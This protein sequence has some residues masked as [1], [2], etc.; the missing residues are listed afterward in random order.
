[1]ARVI[2]EKQAPARQQQ[3]PAAAQQQRAPAA[4]QHRAAPVDIADTSMGGGLVPDGMYIVAIDKAY[5]RTSKTTNKLYI[6]TEMRIVEGEFEG[7]FLF[8][9]FYINSDSDNFRK[10]QKGFLAKMFVSATGA[11]PEAFP[12]LDEDLADLVGAEVAVKVVTEDNDDGKGNKVEVNRVV[13]VSSPNDMPASD[14]AEEQE[15]DT[16]PASRRPP[17][18]TQ[19]NA[20]PVD[21]LDDDIPF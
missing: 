9:P 8:L 12:Q 19:R 3:R 15:D 1:M 4:S 5:F 16:P 20:G 17:A 13:R 11:Q 18:K 21:D 6:N 14:D 10:G 2:P 7:R